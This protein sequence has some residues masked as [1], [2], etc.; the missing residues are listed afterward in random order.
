MRACPTSGRWTARR[1]NPGDRIARQGAVVDPDYPLA[2]SLAGWCHAQRSVYT[3]PT[4]LRR[5]K[6]GPERCRTRWPSER[7]DPLVIAGSARC[8]P[9]CVTTEARAY[10][11]SGRLRSIPMPRGRGADSDGWRVLG[12]AGAGARVFRTAIRLSP[13]DPMNFNNAIGI[14]RPTRSRRTMTRR[15]PTPARPRGTAP[16]P[17][18]STQ[19]RSALAGAGRMNEAREA[20]AEVLRIYPNLTAA[21][22]R[23]RWCFT[24]TTLERMVGPTQE[25]RPAG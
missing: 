21:K 7:D 19:P 24:E 16:H 3:G 5:A 8:T 6:R 9:S 1:G 18:G 23:Q 25:A 12:P 11:G 13:L 17:R 4:T 20:Y 2:L 14:V 22:F 10:S 15:S